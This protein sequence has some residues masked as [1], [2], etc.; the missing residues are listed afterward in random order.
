MKPP[1]TLLLRRS[2]V[3][4]LLSLDECIAAVEQ[5]FRLQ[6]K[7]SWHHMAL[8]VRTFLAAAFT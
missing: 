5:A 8:S 7:A 2:E 1:A 4:E 3:A 6:A